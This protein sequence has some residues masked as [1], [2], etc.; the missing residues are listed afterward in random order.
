MKKYLKTFGEKPEEVVVLRTKVFFDEKGVAEV[1]DEVAEVLE[2]VP[3]Y[4]FMA[5][6]PAEEPEHHA[7][8][9]EENDEEDTSEEEKNE[10][11][12]EA[13]APKPIRPKAPRKQKAR[14]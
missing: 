14:G 10:D 13:P 1:E 7:E 12:E 11:E 2:Q 5:D 3:G 6:T 8:V 4:E 9:I